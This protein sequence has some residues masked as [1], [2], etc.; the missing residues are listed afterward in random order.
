[1]Q[2]NPKFTPCTHIRLSLLNTASCECYCGGTRRDGPVL[3]CVAVRRCAS[4]GA[5]LMWMY[6]ASLTCFARRPSPPRLFAW[7]VLPCE[8]LR[9]MLDIEA[10]RCDVMQGCLAETSPPRVDIQF[11][12][13]VFVCLWSTYGVPMEY[14]VWSMEH[15]W[16]TTYT[17]KWAGGK[18]K[19]K[20]SEVK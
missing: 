19:V 13:C 9:L 4:T 16:S 14:G 18:M 20:V 2:N 10:T 1:M 15:G 11:S 17:N 3:L 6:E 7:L 12:H 8:P 5:V